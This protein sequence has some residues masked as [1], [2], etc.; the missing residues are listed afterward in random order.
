MVVYDVEKASYGVVESV[1]PGSTGTG[2]PTWVWAKW[3]PT[4]EKAKAGTSPLSAHTTKR[5][6]YRPTAT[7]NPGNIEKVKKE[8]QVFTSRP[9][10]HVKTAS[11]PWIGQRLIRVS[12]W[13]TVL[14]LSNK[15]LDNPSG[16]Y[17]TY[18]HPW[19]DRH[20]RSVYITEDGKWIVALGRCVNKRSFGEGVGIDD[21]PLLSSGA[22]VTMAE[23][24][25]VNP[26][27]RFATLLGVDL[28]CAK[29]DG[30]IMRFEPAVG[31]VC[32][33]CSGRAPKYKLKHGMMLYDPHSKI[34]VA[35]SAVRK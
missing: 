20:Q 2:G 14:Y 33:K 18:Y 3:A 15:K 26:W 5:Q 34:I 17:K 19:M 7:H 32:D 28:P 35:V 6:S 21:L 4:L 31:W 11:L 1:G 13:K 25:K 16:K 23:V 8:V 27:G 10:K 30:G 9:A 22:P 12:D 29:G 24:R